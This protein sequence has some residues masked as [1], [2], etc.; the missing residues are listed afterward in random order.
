MT[1]RKM[2]LKWAHLG[3]GRTGR[4]RE[5]VEAHAQRWEPPR[6]IRMRKLV[7]HLGL[8][9]VAQPVLA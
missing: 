9:E 8:A 7:K 2:V 5:I 6:Q 3:A 4:A 1:D